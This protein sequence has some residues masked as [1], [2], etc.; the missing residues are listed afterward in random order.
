MPINFATNIT[1][2]KVTIADTEKGIEVVVP[3]KEMKKFVEKEFLLQMVVDEVE[4]KVKNVGLSDVL[5]GKKV[6]NVT[7]ANGPFPK[8]E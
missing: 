1:D 3:F 2:N 6:I 7:V 4:G 5:L 8:S